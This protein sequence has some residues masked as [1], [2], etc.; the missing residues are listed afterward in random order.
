MKISDKAI[1]RI[2]TINACCII[3]VILL[4]IFGNDLFAG[5]DETTMILFQEALLLASIILGVIFLL[6]LGSLYKLSTKMGR[7]W[8]FLG[9]GMLCWFLGELIF[10]ILDLD[11]LGSPFPSI[12]DIFYIL[13]YPFLAIGL[14]IQTGLL[15]IKLSVK[16]I[17]GAIIV[18]VASAAVIFV[19]VLLPLIEEWASTTDLFG[20]FV[21][22][23]Y[24]VLDIFLLATVIFV[25][26]KL[27]HGK[28][29]SAWILIL[30]GLVM[31]TVADTL[32][33]SYPQDD[34]LIIFKLYDLAFFISYMLIL[35]G[36]LKVI[37]LMSSG[38]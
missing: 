14:L 33:S 18:I 26:V 10:T 38:K 9:L 34:P 3:L 4:W 22:A 35:S 15:K 32:Y 13:A 29:N 20:S 12:A 28:I 36:S 2:F 37:N 30:L 21:E 24:P 1:K 5:A 16:E 17:I 7:I 27:R 25:Y 8:L 19:I 6:S 23:L 11:P 31:M